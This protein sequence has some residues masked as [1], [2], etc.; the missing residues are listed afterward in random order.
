MK[1]LLDTSVLVAAMVEKHPAHSTAYPW[2]KRIKDGDDTGVVAAHSIAEL[3]AVLSALPVQPRIS[4]EI[5]WQLIE[6]NVLRIC[7]I[8]S[9]STEDY[10]TTV[11]RLVQLGLTGGVVYDA[12]ILQAGWNA[13]VDLVLTLNPKD[14]RRVC[15]ELAG[16]IVS[17]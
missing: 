7:E 2:L 14:F 11:N 12:L 10:I 17:P 13:N 5:A 9:A 15:P 3:Y 8:L 4:P 16:K 1:L 6:H